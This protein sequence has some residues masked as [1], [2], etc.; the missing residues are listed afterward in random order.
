MKTQTTDTHTYLLDSG[1]EVW[2][3]PDEYCPR[4]IVKRPRKIKNSGTT[5]SQTMQPYQQIIKYNES[6]FIEDPFYNLIANTSID[7]QAKLKTAKQL[8][9][10]SEKL[11]RM[12][13]ERIEGELMDDEELWDDDNL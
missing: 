12:I 5:L 3:E 7:N 13:Q 1:L 9:E 10:L 2:I 6:L 4:L 11:E 8:K